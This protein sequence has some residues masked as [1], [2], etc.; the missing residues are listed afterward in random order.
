MNYNELKVKG[1][2]SFAG[3]KKRERKNTCDTGPALSDL[4]CVT[5]V[6]VRSIMPCQCNLVLHGNQYFDGWLYEYDAPGAD[7]F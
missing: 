7:V 1:V 5:F 4:Q 6:L 2:K 3:L